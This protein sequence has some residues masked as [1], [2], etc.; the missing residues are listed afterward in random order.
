MP[1][2]SSTSNTNSILVTGVGG[3]AG[4]CATKY[5]LHK[6]RAVIGTDMCT[7]NSNVAHFIEVPAA[8]EASFIP[9]M[10]KIV[11]DFEV[12]LLVPTVSEEL[13]IFASEKAAF[14][15]QG[16]HVMIAPYQA[17][18]I[19]NDKLKTALFLDRHGI[20][21]PRTL[22][23][24]IP[25]A[26][27][28]KSL[29][30]PVIAK[31]RISSGGRGITLHTSHEKLAQERRSNIVYQEFMSGEEYDANL[32]VNRKGELQ[33]CVVL[34]KTVL[35][36]GL[37]GNALAVERVHREDIVELCSRAVKALGIMGPADIDI[38]EDASGT[39]HLL[40]VNARLGANALSAREVMDDLLA[41][42]ESFMRIVEGA[43]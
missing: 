43:S 21:V 8:S 29:G 17:V 28:S 42:W 2:H 31:P 11:R 27:V 3:P 34:R 16:C 10:L 39:P 9:A 38:R 6:G 25:H 19:A 40:E 33:S 5:M 36:E 30:L 18:D 12:S 24:D 14:T 20:A 22:P 13:P 35:R 4:K 41:D 37:V 32:F 7:V 15:A 23:G 1:K 26:Y